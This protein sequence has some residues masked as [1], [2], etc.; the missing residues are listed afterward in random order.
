MLDQHLNIIT[1]VFKLY[2]KKLR[3][4]IGQVYIKNID[5]VEDE[6]NSYEGKEDF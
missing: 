6:I 1:Q 5:F 3:N 2:G 4:L